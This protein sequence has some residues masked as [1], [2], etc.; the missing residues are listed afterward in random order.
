MVSEADARRHLRLARTVVIKAG[1]PMITHVDGNIALGRIGALV[2]QI[3]VLR[4]QGRDCVLITSGAISTGQH[5]MRRT[6][7]L[8]RSIRESVAGGAPSVP[9]APA[10][11]VG[12]SL[13]MNL[14]AV[15]HAGSRCALP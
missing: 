8:S 7:A 4:A 2:E 6:M 15:P 5:R 10:A 3:A 11:A 9:Q 13:L 1:T 12:Q 14:C